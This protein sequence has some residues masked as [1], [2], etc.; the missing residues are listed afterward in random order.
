MPLVCSNTCGICCEWQ[1]AEGGVSGPLEER[2]SQ[3][4]RE[5]EGEQVATFKVDLPH[6]LSGY[7]Q[8][9]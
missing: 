1:V 4:P 2:N 8:E 5:G 9:K 6:K 7:R 3:K